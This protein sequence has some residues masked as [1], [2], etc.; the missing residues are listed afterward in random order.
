MGPEFD[1]AMTLVF[2]IALA[3]LALGFVWGAVLF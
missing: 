3:A 1:G 2:I